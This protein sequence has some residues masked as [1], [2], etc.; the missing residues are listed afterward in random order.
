VSREKLHQTHHLAV[1]QRIPE[2]SKKKTFLSPRLLTMASF[3]VRNRVAMF[4][5]PSVVTEPEA[6]VS[7]NIGAVKS[8]VSPSARSATSYLSSYSPKSARSSPLGVGP[9]SSA[10]N[11]PRNNDTSGNGVT[12]PRTKTPR[13]PTTPKISTTPRRKQQTKATGKIAS[14]FL[15]ANDQASKPVV[16]PSKSN[17]LP[18]GWGTT[19]LRSSGLVS[20]SH[21]KNA[22]NHESQEENESRDA[23]WSAT[24]EITETRDEDLLQNSLNAAQVVLE[25]E[26]SNGGSSN[27]SSRSS[28]STRELSDV[29]KRALNIAKKK[30][31]SPNPQHN[32][33]PAVLHAPNAATG[34][35]T[36]T[37]SQSWKAAA[38]PAKKT[39]PAS[40]PHIPKSIVAAPGSANNVPPSPGAGRVKNRAAAV[41]AAK[42][43]RAKT[44]I[45]ANNANTAEARR[46]LLANAKKNKEKK[47]EAARHLAEKKEDDDVEVSARLGMKATRVLAM[48]NS[49]HKSDHSRDDTS[50]V[51]SFESNRSRRIDHPAFAAR[52]MGASPKPKKPDGNDA[53]K[54]FSAELISS[55]RHFS[56]ARTEKEVEKQAERSSIENDGRPPTPKTLRA[57]MQGVMVQSKASS[58]TRGDASMD[59]SFLEQEDSLHSMS[60]RNYFEE[61]AYIGS[62]SDS[63]TFSMLS[64]MNDTPSNTAFR[65]YGVES[66]M[67]PGPSMRSGH[68]MAHSII[69][70]TPTAHS[71]ARNA[72][73]DYLLKTPSTSKTSGADPEEEK[74]GQDKDNAQSLR[75]GDSG[76]RS[77]SPPGKS[78]LISEL[79]CIAEVVAKRCCIECRFC[80]RGRCEEGCRS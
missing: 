37:P 43:N 3:S 31:L 36:T 52:A 9:Y 80:A 48:K 6:E 47:D 33:G 28:L 50:S 26:K 29:A 2:K 41:A 59:D 65:K 68:S 66:A 8:P 45:T 60:G 24:K 39:G 73:F 51:T 21:F 5:K 63:N 16:L 77:T 46:A 15:S 71:T 54:P 22:S 49:F 78:L 62:L 19:N 30:S 69:S 11:S 53:D 67:S 79:S 23:S 42:K 38:G 34:P 27:A 70:T 74:S 25:E 4:E 76:A 13:K 57:A 18:P 58:H 35:A 20:G 55:F 61:G 72:D 14:P 64:S 75:S 10:R 7:K 1:K 32:S 17:T 44:A 12:S 40:A 56:A